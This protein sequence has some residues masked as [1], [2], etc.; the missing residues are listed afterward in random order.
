MNPQFVEQMMGFPEGWTD[1]TRWCRKSRRLERG[2][3]G[4]RG[5]IMEMHEYDLP[6]GKLC[7]DPKKHRSTLTR[8]RLSPAT[9]GEGTSPTEILNGLGGEDGPPNIS[10]NI[11]RESTPWT[12]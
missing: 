12:W 9:A 2:N 6:N 11:S 8:E 3:N 10:R 7:F 5:Q 1:L 4:N